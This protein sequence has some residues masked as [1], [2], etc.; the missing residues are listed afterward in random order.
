MIDFAG[1]REQRSERVQLRHY[2]A[3]GP[4][5]D[6]GVVVD[7]VQQDLGGPIPAGGHVVGVRGTRPGFPGQSEVGDLHQLR[8]AA[9]EV[10]GLHVPVEKPVPVHERQPLEYLYVHGTP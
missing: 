4:Q 2:A 10:L 9:Q 7:G 6:G 3:D 1:A 5:I 8:T